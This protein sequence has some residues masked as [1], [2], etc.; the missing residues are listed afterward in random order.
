MKIPVIKPFEVSAEILSM[1]FE[2]IQKCYAYD[3]F[4]L[5]PT[6]QILSPWPIIIH[7]TTLELV[8]RFIIA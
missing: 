8:S 7:H 3:S 6:I 4:I 2:Q 5:S 1:K